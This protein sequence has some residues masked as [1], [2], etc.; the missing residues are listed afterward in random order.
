M[1]N[2]NTVYKHIA[3][4]QVNQLVDYSTRHRIKKMM[5]CG[6]RDP[7]RES[8]SASPLSIFSAHCAKKTKLSWATCHSCHQTN[9]VTALKET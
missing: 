5:S 3:G 1:A 7:D 4:G 8:W 2:D 6:Q 9:G